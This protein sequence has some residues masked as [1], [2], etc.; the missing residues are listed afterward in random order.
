[1]IAQVNFRELEIVLER[2][3]RQLK[4]NKRE[5]IEDLSLKDKRALFK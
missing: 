2:V 4:V 1:M 3:D 5:L